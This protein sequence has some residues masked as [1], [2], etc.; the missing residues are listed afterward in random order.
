MSKY[1]TMKGLTQ[2]I[3]TNEI[4]PFP[5][6]AKQ[7]PSYIIYK[8]ILTQSE[9]DLI[10]KTSEVEKAKVEFDTF[11]SGKAT[12]KFKQECIDPFE[13]DWLSIKLMKVIKEANKLYNFQ[14]SGF[15]NVFNVLEYQKGHHTSWHM[16]TAPTKLTITLALNEQGIDY[17]GGELEIGG[18]STIPKLEKGDAL[19]MLGYA[20]HCV[21]KVTKGVRRV[22]IA[23]SV[24]DSLK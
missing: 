8:N 16:D 3:T 5:V 21:K 9:C 4:W 18:A 6:R 2:P 7:P 17:E 19:V 13:H 22:L 1:I 12:R 10:I 24:G 11:Y 20:S 14:I 23:W 15:I